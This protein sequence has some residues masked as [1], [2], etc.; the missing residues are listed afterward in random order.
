MRVKLHHAERQAVRIGIVDAVGSRALAMQLGCPGLKRKTVLERCTEVPEL[1]GSHRQRNDVVRSRS[2]VCSNRVGFRRRGRSRWTLIL[3]DSRKI[4]MSVS[5]PRRRPGEI[6]LT[7]GG[8]RNSRGR[9]IRP[10][11]EQRRRRQREDRETEMMCPF[12]V[13]S[14]NTPRRRPCQSR[15]ADI[16]YSPGSCALQHPAETTGIVWPHLGVRKQRQFRAP[17]RSACAGGSRSSRSFPS[18]A[19]PMNRR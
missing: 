8:L 4:R 12:Q 1:A 10:L 6:R 13:P 9:I 15:A 3:P 17:A 14:Q 16:R 11:R 5:G 2:L 7:G 19:A 18:H